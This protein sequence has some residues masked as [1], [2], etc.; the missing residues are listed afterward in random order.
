MFYWREEEGGGEVRRREGG[1]GAGGETRGGELGMKDLSDEG[2]KRPSEKETR[3]KKKQR[4]PENCGV[5]GVREGEGGIE[6]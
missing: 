3:A 2:E 6:Q 5:R 4:E 1:K